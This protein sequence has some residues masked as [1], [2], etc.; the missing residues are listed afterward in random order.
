MSNIINSISTALANWQ[1]RRTTIQALSSLDEHTLRD[2]G[3]SRGEITSVAAELTGRAQRSRVH[4]LRA[5]E[6]E[7]QID[8]P[9]TSHTPDIEWPKAA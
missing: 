9:V 2:I 3:I 6:P 8:D 1:A 5:A 7:I 4:T